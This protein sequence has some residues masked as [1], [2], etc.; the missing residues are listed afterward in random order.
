MT[1]TV[2]DPATGRLLTTGPKLAS[3]HKSGL[4]STDGTVLVVAT[5][6]TT[7]AWETGTGK[8]LWQQAEDE[9]R[10]APAAVVGPVLYSGDPSVAVDLRTKAVLRSAVSDMPRPVGPGHALVVVS[11]NV[12]VFAVKHG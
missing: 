2:N 5:T 11:G 1:Y 8:L 9:K 3:W 10:L 12:Y 6:A 4:A 7:A